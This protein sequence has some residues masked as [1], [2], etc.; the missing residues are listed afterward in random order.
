MHLSKLQYRTFF[1]FTSLS[2]VYF[3]AMIVSFLRCIQH[4]NK[5]DT[6][7]EDSTTLGKA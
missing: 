4:V 5:R 1:V 2:I 6:Q 7:N 3:M